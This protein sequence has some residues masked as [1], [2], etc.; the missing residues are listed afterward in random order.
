MVKISTGPNARGHFKFILGIK[1]LGGFFCWFL[2]FCNRLFRGI[3]L[4][5]VTCRLAHTTLSYSIS[6]PQE[7]DDLC[8]FVVFF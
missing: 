3:Y 8:F 4:P 2:L 7:T 1:V 5:A 6:S